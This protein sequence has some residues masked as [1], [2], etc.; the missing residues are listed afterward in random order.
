[1]KKLIDKM[2][3]PKVATVIAIILA[4]LLVFGMTM[5][6]SGNGGGSSYSSHGHEH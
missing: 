4:A 2:G 5:S 1:M 3:G 6:G